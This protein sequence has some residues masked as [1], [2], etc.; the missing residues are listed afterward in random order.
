MDTMVPSQ[1]A[2]VIQLLMDTLSPTCT[3]PRSISLRV[4]VT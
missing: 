1:A 2:P 3:L 4:P